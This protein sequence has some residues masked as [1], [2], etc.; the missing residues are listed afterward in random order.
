MIPR[1]QR[2]RA[3]ADAAFAEAAF[4]DLGAR[5][6]PFFSSTYLVEFMLI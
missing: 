5:T 2:A 4:A 3:N 1:G 6:Q